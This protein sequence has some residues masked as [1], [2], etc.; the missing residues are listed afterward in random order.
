MFVESPLIRKDVIEEREYQAAIARSSLKRSTLVVL[1]TGLGKTAIAI[2]VVAEVLRT[3]GGKVLF[4]APTKPL[5][6]QHT[7]SL[8]EALS[9]D[10]IAMFTGEATPPDEREL[11]WRENQIIC[12]TP[13]VIKND[14]RAGR[15][16]LGDVTLIVFDEAHRAVGDYAYVDIAAAYKERRGG[17]VM[18]TTASPGSSSEKILEVCGNIGL[19]AVEI[20]TEFD[21]DVVKYVQDIAIEPL[22]V[23]VTAEGKEVAGPLRKAFEECIADIKSHGFLKEEEMVTR[24]DLLTL[25]DQIHARLQGNEKNF[26]LYR[27][28]TAVALAMK[29]DHAVELA[30]T[31][32]LE[33][34]RNYFERAEKS[35]GSEGASRADKQMLKNRWVKEAMAKALGTRVEHTKIARILWVVKDQ[36]TRKQDSRIIVFTH[37]R[38]TS[39]IITRELATIPGVKPVRFVGQATRGADKGLKQKEQVKIIE[40]FGKGEFNVLVATSVAE[41]GL[42]IPSTDLVVFYEPVPSEIRTIQRRGRTGR[43]RPGRVVVLVTKDTRD[44]IY[45]YSARRKE[46]RMH[47][48]L[49]RLRRELKQKIFV[50]EPSGETF[51]TAQPEKVMEHLREEAREKVESAEVRRV[52]KK[53]QTKLS[54]F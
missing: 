1:P 3:R 31:Q 8:R 28:A 12:S 27:A 34:V 20:R 18:G 43:R 5:V 45:Y 54:E 2:R 50:G 21:S 46:K 10:R 33:S 37:Y 39:E 9:V 11:L 6:E 41:E 49:E 26:H 53:G 24:R 52:D 44:E 38:D 51:V 22:R 19:Q 35:A 4:L 14:I 16:T 40:K 29:I 30:E 47:Q 25:G 32:G 23:D 13:Q 48:E 7:A 42:D 15:F 36:L 17:L